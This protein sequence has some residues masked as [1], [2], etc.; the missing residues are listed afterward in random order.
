MTV[1]ETIEAEIADLEAKVAAAKAKLEALPA[2]VH[3]WE[4]AVWEKL[5][6]FVKGL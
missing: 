6:A 4:Q 2:E 1:K 5:V 3:S